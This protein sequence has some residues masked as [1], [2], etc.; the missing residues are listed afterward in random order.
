MG[1]SN[2]HGS[3][4]KLVVVV[5]SKSCLV[6]IQTRNTSGGDGKFEI[7]EGDNVPGWRGPGLPC[8]ATLLPSIHFETTPNGSLL[9]F[10]TA[11]E[12]GS[13]H[14]RFLVLTTDTS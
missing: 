6:S 8:A 12:E 5:G 1:P 13:T 3:V 10:N 9:P 14:R 4:Y 11:P 7:L 2:K